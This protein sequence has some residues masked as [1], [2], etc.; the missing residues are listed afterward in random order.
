M[1][2][3][4][5]FRVHLEGEPTSSHTSE[6]EGPGSAM[7]FLEASKQNPSGDRVKDMRG[8]FGGG[9]IVVME[10]LGLSWEND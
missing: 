3:N 7:E 6:D 2:I 8:S 10:A 9:L 5:G 1:A 4:E